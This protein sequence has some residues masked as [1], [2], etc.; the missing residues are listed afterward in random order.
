MLTEDCC[1]IAN[2][3]S[4]SPLHSN[5]SGRHNPRLCTNLTKCQNMV[6]RRRRVVRRAAPSCSATC[7]SPVTTSLL[8]STLRH[9][10]F[11]KERVIKLR[12]ELQ[13]RR[14]R[15]WSPGKQKKKLGLYL[16]SLRSSVFC[17]SQSQFA[18]SEREWHWLADRRE[19][20]GLW[21]LK[22]GNYGL[23]QSRNREKEPH[24]HWMALIHQETIA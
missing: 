12:I 21:T 15:A 18:K 1:W 3:R 24:H 16:S 2:G 17:T 22:R 11:R 4:L 6:D 20:S 14:Q 10:I 19:G 9:S 23:G 13:V 8:F 7:K 5:S